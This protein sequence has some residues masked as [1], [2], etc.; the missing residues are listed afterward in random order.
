MR[1]SAMARVLFVDYWSSGK[2][3]QGI[4]HGVS[5]DLTPVGGV[6]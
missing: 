1:A 5:V 2:L 6:A 4:M 3:F